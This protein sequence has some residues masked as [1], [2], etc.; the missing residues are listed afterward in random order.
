MCR[1]TIKEGEKRVCDWRADE[2]LCVQ[3]ESGKSSNQNPKVES[4]GEPTRIEVAFPQRSQPV[5]GDFPRR[6]P[7]AAARCL[8]SPL[9]L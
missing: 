8:H 5:L 7:E 3:K 2:H 6:K 9:S 4:W 1:R